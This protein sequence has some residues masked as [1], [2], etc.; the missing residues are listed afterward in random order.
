M[1]IEQTLKILKNLLPGTNDDEFLE[2]LALQSSYIVFDGP[3]ETLF[4]PGDAPK[5]FYWILSG[6]VEEEVSKD[7]IVLLGRGNMIGLEEFLHSRGHLSTWT[8]HSRT[9]ALFIDSRCY[10]S[11]SRKLSPSHFHM[12]LSVQLLKLKEAC[13]GRPSA[14]INKVG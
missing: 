10:D 7:V 9:E 12:E 1:S 2:Q 11:L 13:Q 8:T 6:Q 3:D 14:V 4:R 5:G